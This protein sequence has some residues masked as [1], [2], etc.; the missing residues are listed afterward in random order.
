MD[1]STIEALTRDA[2]LRDQEGRT[3][4][5]LEKSPNLVW[6]SHADNPS[7]GWRCFSFP[8]LEVAG[9][10]EVTEW[11]GGHHFCPKQSS[12]TSCIACDHGVDWKIRCWFFNRNKYQNFRDVQQT[13]GSIEKHRKQHECAYLG[14]QRAW[15]KYRRKHKNDRKNI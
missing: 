14:Y 15:D 12:P 13:R 1:I 4:K 11:Y 7:L 10:S 6:L 8:D 2:E 5:I 3:Y 9:L